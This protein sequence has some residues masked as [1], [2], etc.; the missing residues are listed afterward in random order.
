[1]RLFLLISLVGAVC[2][3]SATEKF[4]FTPRVAIEPTVNCSTDETC[5]HGF[6]RKS[7]CLC[8]Y[9][10]ATKNVEEPCEYSRYSRTTALLLQIFLGGFGVGISVLGWDGAIGLY[11]GFLIM[12]CCTSFMSTVYADAG[13]DH[14]V[15]GLCSGCLSALGVIAVLAVY[16]TAIVF[17]A[18]NECMDT[19]GFACG[20]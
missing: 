6:C 3:R 13:D 12:F 15:K 16:I 20:S 9:N 5:G 2:A 10:W 8:D 17:I 19:N 7:R 14:V 11:W 4:P 18:G 1:M